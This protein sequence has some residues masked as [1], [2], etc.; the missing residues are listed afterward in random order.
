MKRSGMNTKK[1]KQKQRVVKLHP[2][3]YADLRAYSEARH[4]AMSSLATAAIG[5]A[6]RRW[7]RGLVLG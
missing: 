5:H 3:V 4:L 1:P 7:R 6:L 2:A